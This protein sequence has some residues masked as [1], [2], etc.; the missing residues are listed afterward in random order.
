MEVKFWRAQEIRC[1]KW[2]TVGGCQQREEWFPGRA[3]KAEIDLWRDFD[4]DFGGGIAGP[5]LKVI[6]TPSIFQ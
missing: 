1:G 5:H 6:K 4:Q 2:A 3:Q